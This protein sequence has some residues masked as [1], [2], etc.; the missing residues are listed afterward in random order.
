MIPKSGFRFPARAKP[1]QSRF[2]TF[3]ATAGEGRSEKIMFKNKLKRNGGSTP[4]RL[5]ISTALHQLDRV[6]KRQG[7]DKN[8]L[9]D[10]NH[11]GRACARPSRSL[12]CYRLQGTRIKSTLWRNAGSCGRTQAN[13]TLAIVTFGRTK[14][15]R[16]G[17]EDSARTASLK[18]NRTP[19]HTAQVLGIIVWIARA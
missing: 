10:K 18:L 8:Q 1:C 7:R 6:P 9:R 16:S 3:D 17:N 2:R 15:D 13:L 5:T 12:R 19:A 14:R 4:F 11:D